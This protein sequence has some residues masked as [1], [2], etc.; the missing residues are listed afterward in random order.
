MPL[1][2]MSESFVECGIIL[3]RK[4]GF[5][6][7]CVCACVFFLCMMKQRGGGGEFYRLLHSFKCN[8]PKFVQESM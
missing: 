3:P 7:V 6:L 4:F 5:E 1:L 2:H 8:C